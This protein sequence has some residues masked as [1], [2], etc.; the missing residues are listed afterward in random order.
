MPK[1]LDFGLGA[2]KAPDDP[3]D[4][5]YG[6]AMATIM[7]A[8]LPS[9]I[10]NRE[11][12]TPVW[13]QGQEGSCVGMAIAGAAEFLYWKKLGARPGFSPRAAYEW[14]KEYD[15]IPGV[16]HEGSTMRAGLKAWQKMGMCPWPRWPYVDGD[17]GG[18]DVEAERRAR[19]YPLWRYE[20]LDNDANIIF[21]MRHAIHKQGLVLVTLKVHTGWINPSA[22]GKIK[23][24]SNYKFYGYHAAMLVANYHRSGYFWLRNSWDLWGVDGY[25]QIGYDDIE[26]NL[27][28]AWVPMIKMD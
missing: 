13:N 26:N 5:E 11:Y 22:D 12:C 10:D 28:D 20:K 21:Q 4:F 6:V 27:V 17:P 14:A 25:G 7:Q 24:Q 8:E 15:H 1:K 23:Y 16:D 2:L 18:K 3:L 9:W 19:G